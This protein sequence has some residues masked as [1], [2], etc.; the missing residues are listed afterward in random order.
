MRI[1]IHAESFTH[2]RKNKCQFRFGFYYMCD[3]KLFRNNFAVMYIMKF[4]YGIHNE[5]NLN[6][7]VKSINA[8]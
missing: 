7:V 2:M 8:S 6:Y 1:L 4:F 5:V 3:M